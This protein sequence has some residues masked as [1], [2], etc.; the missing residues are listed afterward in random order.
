MFKDEIITWLQKVLAGETPALPHDEDQFITDTLQLADWHGVTALVHHE[1]SKD[2]NLDKYPEKFNEQLIARNNRIVAGKLLWKQEM[3][4][5]QSALHT[6]NM[7]SL[8]IKGFPLSYVLYPGPHLRLYSDIDILFPDFESTE[9]AWNILTDMGYTRPVTASGKYISHQFSCYR[10]G[11][12]GFPF[13]LDLHWR[14]NNHYFFANALMF[15]ELES[16]SMVLPGIEPEMRTLS[17]EYALLYACMH[18][19]AHLPFNESNRLIWLYDIH[20]LAKSFNADQWTHFVDLAAGKKLSSVCLDGL[21][22]CKTRF[23]TGLPENVLEKLQQEGTD[24]PIKP[25]ELTSAW[26]YNLTIYKTMPGWTERFCLL[27]EHLFP[28]PDYMLAK[29]KTA[30]K[31]LLPYLYTKRIVG[32]VIK[33][34]KF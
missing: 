23:N 6:A 15:E 28:P 25:E 20:L 30:N 8:L 16:S 2:N 22:E 11:T 34:F 17:P 4:N 1:L 21:L 5:V 27:R 12:S 33:I 13:A 32:A 10:S 24:D 14:V 9:K 31:W 29:Y 19:I 3:I 26:K 7:R 18:R